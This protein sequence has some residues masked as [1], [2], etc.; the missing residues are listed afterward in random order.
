NLADLADNQL[1][2][3]FG[4]WKVSSNVNYLKKAHDASVALSKL[5]RPVTLNGP[6]LGEGIRVDGS[7]S[8]HNPV[9][10]DTVY[11]QLYTGGYGVVFLDVFFKYSALLTG[12]YALSSECIEHVYI[13]IE[14]GL[15]GAYH[16]GQYDPHTLGRGIS[17]PQAERPG[18]P[19]WLIWYMKRRQQ[20]GYGNLES[21]DA[22]EVSIED[23]PCNRINAHWLNDSLTAKFEGF[24][25]FNK[26]VSTRTVGTET[27]NGENLKGFY[28]GCGTYFLVAGGHEYRNIQPLLDWQ[29]LPGLTAEH[30]PDFSFPLLEW[31][32][33][34]WGS[35]DFAGVLGT[36]TFLVNRSYTVDCGITA[37]QL[38]KGN[39]QDTRKTIIVH[40]GSVY[41]LG[42]AGSLEKATHPVYTTVN[43]CLFKDEVIIKCAGG[44]EQKISTGISTFEQTESIIHDGFLYD[45]GNYNLPTITITIEERQENWRTI[46]TSAPNR[47]QKAKI[48]TIYTEHKPGSETYFWR[49]SRHSQMQH[50]SLDGHEN[51]REWQII[52]LT[53]KLGVESGS[54]VHRH[55]GTVAGSIFDA[56]RTLFISNGP[57]FEFSS[58]CIFII[59]YKTQPSRWEITISDPTHKLENITINA[60]WHGKEQ[61]LTAHFP[62]GEKQG[63]SATVSL[64]WPN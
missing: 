48:L 55:A 34:A 36:S 49:I 10:G 35:H 8:Q 31:G 37:L 64:F 7:F 26:V 38:T 12:A 22:I 27:G 41:C 62:A 43:Q 52:G 20:K 24:A 61:T 13:F 29:R 11:S 63:E 21:F 56:P 19:Q 17:R 2:W 59:I 4:G 60:T 16:N 14:K 57:S 58:P 15:L 54:P 6:E 9:Q 53:F 32:K 47:M 42:H 18:T 50:F 44:T 45:F 46:N 33:N 23:L 3:A 5:Y 51:T 30:D 39:L 25:F 28:L 40:Q 1:M